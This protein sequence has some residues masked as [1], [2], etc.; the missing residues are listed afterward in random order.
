MKLIIRP[1][2]LTDAESF[3]SIYAP[4]VRDTAVS[5]EYEIPGLEEFRERIRRTLTRYPWLAAELG[6]EVVGYAYTGAFNKRAAYDWSAETSVYL[7]TDCRRQGVGKRLYQTLE[8]VSQA[9]N[10]QNLNACIAVPAGE[11]PHLTRD[12]IA[13]HTRMGYRLA[14][15]FHQCGYKFGTWYGMAWMEKQIGNHPLEPAPFIPFPELPE[16]TLGRLF[17]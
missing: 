12:S 13:F 4:Y 14:G 7:R 17:R 15:E 5:F 6:G 11:D 9:Q 16:N 3:L 2:V 1:A 10:V 8:A